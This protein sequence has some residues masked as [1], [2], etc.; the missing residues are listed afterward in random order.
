MPPFLSAEAGMK[1]REFIGLI[2]GAATVWPLAARSQ[3]DPHIK[4]IGVLSSSA[5]T[6]ALKARL[7]V[8][9]QAMLQLGWSAGRNARFDI[10]WGEGD[11]DI[12]RKQTEELVALA[13]DIIFVSGSSALAPLQQA[14]RKVPIVFTT[15]VDPVGAGYVASLAQPGGNITGFMLFEYGISG[16]WLEMLKQ[17]LPGMKRTAVLRDPAIA[18]GIGQFAIIQSVA[19]SLG[20]DVIPF[21]VATATEIERSITTFAGAQNGGL[22]L[23]ASALSVTHGDLIIELTARHKLPAIYTTRDYVVR[24]GLISYGPDL[25]DQQKR[26]ASYVDRILKGEKPADL[27]VQAPTKYELV[28][29]LK[30]AK[31]LGLTMPATLLAHADEVIE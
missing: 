14:T 15:V 27:P 5:A 6:P 28:I 25:I 20:V 3:Q 1:R 13:P 10:R 22:I 31:A 7:E 4:L 2:G 21:G 23:T 29:N 17:I 30:T 19:P 8:F 16:K 24:G 26:A 11:P 18:S 12:I 9:L